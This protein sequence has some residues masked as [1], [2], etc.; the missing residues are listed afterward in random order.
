ML[1]VS[2]FGIVLVVYGLTTSTVLLAVA[3]VFAG[4]G[5]GYVNVV[6]VTWLQNR[7]PLSLL[8]RVMSL[9]MLASVGLVPISQA[10]SG[11]LIKVSLVGV[12]IGA[13]LLLMIVTL[14]IMFVPAV[15]DIELPVVAAEGEPA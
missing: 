10:L 14:R 12:F 4:A 7:V 1:L 8:G 3:T 5:S 6:F 11:A 2:L 15:R 9:V 13:G